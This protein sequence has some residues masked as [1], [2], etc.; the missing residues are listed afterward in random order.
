MVGQLILLIKCDILRH[1]Q[2]PLYCLKL[3]RFIQATDFSRQTR[4]SYILRVRPWVASKL[5]LIINSFCVPLVCRYSGFQYLTSH[6]CGF[7]CFLPNV[8]RN[9]VGF[10][11]DHCYSRWLRCVSTRR[12]YIRFVSGFD[13]VTLH[14]NHLDGIICSLTFLLIAQNLVF[15]VFL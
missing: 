12:L 5:W 1:T 3:I 11:S 9:G 10:S 8:H 2:N 6:K 14:I 4:G 7:S 15:L 13:L